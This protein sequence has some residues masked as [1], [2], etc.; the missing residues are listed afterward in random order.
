MAKTPK[1]RTFRFDAGSIEEEWAKAQNN[2]NYSMKLLVKLAIKAYGIQDLGYSL[3]ERGDFHIIRDAM[4]NQKNS[5]Y[6]LNFG[7]NNNSIDTVE[8]ITSDFIDR[9]DSTKTV[10]EVTKN[11]TRSHQ[12]DQNEV[13]EQVDHSSKPTRKQINDFFGNGDL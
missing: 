7:N 9:N 1:T 3:I 12:E 5:S 8:N 10:E 2:F 13:D 11:T 4:S 6:D